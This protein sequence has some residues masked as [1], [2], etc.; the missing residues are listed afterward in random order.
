MGRTRASAI[1]WV[2]TWTH[3]DPENRLLRVRVHPFTV[4]LFFFYPDQMYGQ[5]FDPGKKNETVNGLLLPVW[6]QK[7]D[8]NR[9]RWFSVRPDIWEG[10]KR[11][12]HTFIGITHHIKRKRA[13]KLLWSQ[14][15]DGLSLFLFFFFIFLDHNR[16]YV[17]CHQLVVQGKMKE[18]KRCVNAWTKFTA[19]RAFTHSLAN[20]HNNWPES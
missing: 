12:G 18:K 2:H 13:R 9:E 20:R 19:T 3:W 16:H 10:E 14:I 1:L 11:L 7:S 6:P 15:N 17:L 4:S 5:G 8:R